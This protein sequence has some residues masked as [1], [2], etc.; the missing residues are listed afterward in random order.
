MDDRRKRLLY[1]ATHRG[2]KESDFIIGGFFTRV[3]ADLSDTQVAEA[4]AL[5]EENDI[6]LINWV[7]GRE[8][9]PERWRAGLLAE[10]MAHYRG[11]T[12]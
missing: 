2:T 9:V 5:L 6:D 4:E 8:A 1:R 11:L 12:A 3:T 7:T 10:V